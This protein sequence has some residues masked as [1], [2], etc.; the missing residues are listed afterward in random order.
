[1]AALLRLREY[2]TPSKEDEELLM[3]VTNRAKMRI[4]PKDGRQHTQ[5]IVFPEQKKMRK[6]KRGRTT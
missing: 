2:H 4:H 6:T 5:F 3:T 1:M